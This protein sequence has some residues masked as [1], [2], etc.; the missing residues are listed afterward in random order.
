[1]KEMMTKLTVDDLGLR[2]S[3][4]DEGDESGELRVVDNGSI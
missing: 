3:L 2:S 1:M 4:S